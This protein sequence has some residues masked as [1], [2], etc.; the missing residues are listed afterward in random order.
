[1]SILTLSG[2]PSV[3]SRSGLVLAHLRT[4]LE[5]AGERTRHL[6][7]RD[8]PAGPLLA[9]RVDDD[10]IAAATRAVAEA[11][12]VVL[13]TPVYKAAYSGLLKAFLDLLPQTGL[14][15]KI[16]LPIATGGS[17]AH[18]LAIDY[19]LR[20]VLSALGSRQILPGIF[21]VDQQIDTSA[22]SAS[23]DGGGV[24]QARFDAA[25]SARLDEGLLRVRDA[26]AHARI[27][28]PLDALDVVPG[29]FVQRAAAAA[30]V[31]ERCTA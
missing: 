9:A 15:D 23:S 13:A 21:A 4:A 1:M 24:R 3:Q 19:A 6:D 7:L 17:L 30:V 8:L 20:P 5:A 2:S 28:V 25:L 10:A 16:V 12:V 29:A 14:R 11:Q 26:L 22:S 31:A 18:A 27:E